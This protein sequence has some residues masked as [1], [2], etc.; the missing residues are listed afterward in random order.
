MSGLSGG[1][2][3]TTFAGAVEPRIKYLYAVAGSMP[4][5]VDVPPELVGGKNISSLRAD[6]EQSHPFFRTVADYLDLY[7]LDVLGS[8]RRAIHFYINK[9]ECCFPGAAS[10]AFSAQ[11][12]DL[13]RQIT[14]NSLEFVVDMK[15]TR[16]ELGSATLETILAD[17]TGQGPER[18]AAH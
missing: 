3:T 6:Y 17:F 5:A 9:D 13:A 7:L 18:T 14:G 15:A 16:H 4:F 12:T 11:M 10:Y 2:W 1:G 8:D